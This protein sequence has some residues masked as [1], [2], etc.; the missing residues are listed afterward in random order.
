MLG[1]LARACMPLKLVRGQQDVAPQLGHQLL[2]Q[3]AVALLQ[4][5][6][7]KRVEGAAVSAARTVV[8]G[9]G[10]ARERQIGRA[11]V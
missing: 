11:H 1:G 2:A 7:G 5:Q 3:A 9:K 8:G 6:G 10:N 4:K